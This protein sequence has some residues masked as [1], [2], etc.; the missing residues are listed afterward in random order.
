VTNNP[1]RSPSRKS[2]AVS[3][4]TVRAYALALPGAEEGT[5]Y[6]TPAFKVKGKMFVRRHQTED[7]VVVR[8]SFE[9]RAMRMKVDPESFYITDHYASYPA[10]LVRLS[11]VDPDDLRELLED[12][13]RINAPAKLLGTDG[14]RRRT[15]PVPDEVAESASPPREAPR[16]PKAPAASRRRRGERE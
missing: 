2:A 1:K 4:E 5:S 10:M 15:R 8:I 9:D 16:P 14:T 6:G 7:A 12:S 3:F 13:W 11:T